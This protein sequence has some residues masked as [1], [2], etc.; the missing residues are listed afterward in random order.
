MTGL[1]PATQ[2]TVDGLSAKH[3][4]ER[5]PNHVD[6]RDKPVMT[7]RGVNLLSRSRR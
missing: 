1:V 3:L 6:G 5:K 2:R 4:D 7:A